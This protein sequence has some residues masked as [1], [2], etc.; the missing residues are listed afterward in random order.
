MVADLWQRKGK[1]SGCL[2]GG[3]SIVLQQFQNEV[4]F[5]RKGSGIAL[6][7]SLLRTDKLEQK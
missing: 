5:P 2:E 3:A 1:I 6:K 7:V 4:N